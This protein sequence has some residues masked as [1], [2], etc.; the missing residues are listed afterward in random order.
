METLVL[1]S[2]FF[3]WRDLG[4]LAPY[5]GAYTNHCFQIDDSDASIGSVLARFELSALPE[6]AGTR[7]FVLCFLKIITPYSRLQVWSANIDLPTSHIVS[8][9]QLLWDP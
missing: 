8:G 6:H 3:D 9:F 2:P 1:R 5:T 4:R 7:T